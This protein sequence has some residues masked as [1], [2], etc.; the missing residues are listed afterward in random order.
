MAEPFDSVP[1]ARLPA[2]PAAAHRRRLRG[3]GRQALP[4]RRLDAPAR[5]VRSK[6]TACRGWSSRATC[7]NAPAATSAMCS[8]RT[9]PPS[10]TQHRPELAGAPFEALGVSLVM[11]PRN[12]HVPTVHMNVRMFAALPDGQAPVSWFG[13]GMDL[14]PYYGVDEDA[15]HF[16]RC[17]RDALVALRR[18]QVP[19]LQEMVRRVLLPQAPRRGARRRRR[20]LRRLCRAGLRAQLRDDACGGRCLRA[21]YLPIVQRR[22]ATPLRRT[23]ARIPALPARALCRVQP[24]LRP[25]HALRAADRAGAPKAS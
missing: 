8:G 9:L 23:R 13:G 18:G 25:R 11:H 24:G 3:R 5:A 12:P 15:V 2:R 1:G 16:H 20:V 10:A 21:A 19:A 4:Q 22:R 7:S 17:C 6:A 14:T